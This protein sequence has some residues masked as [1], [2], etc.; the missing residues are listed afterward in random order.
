MV[1]LELGPSPPHLHSR[2]ELSQ[3][4]IALLIFFGRKTQFFYFWSTTAGKFTAK[5]EKICLNK[6]IDHYCKI[7]SKNFFGKNSSSAQLSSARSAKKMG[8]LSS[9]SSA[10]KF[11]QLSSLS[12]GKI[13]AQL[14]S[15]QLSFFFQNLQL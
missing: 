11:C 6:K 15:A 9:L 1:D 4:Y 3:I 8:Q 5:L 14:S 7:P 13:L 12:S 10:S 2:A